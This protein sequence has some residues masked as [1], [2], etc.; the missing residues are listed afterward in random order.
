MNNILKN[1]RKKR[2]MTQEQLARNIGISTAYVR[3]IEGG[4]I[5]RSDIM[6][7]YQDEFNISV[8]ELFPDYF[9]V[10]NDKKFII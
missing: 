9:S 7:R 5:P 3:K 4:Y 8:K 1:E 10:F 6:V 2:K